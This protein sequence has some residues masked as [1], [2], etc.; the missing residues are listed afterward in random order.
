MQE[1]AKELAKAKDTLYTELKFFKKINHGFKRQETKNLK[2]VQRKGSN[3]EEEEEID[4]KNLPVKE[5]IKYLTV[6]Q[7]RE[8]SEETT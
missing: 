3:D 4:I 7:L 1:N 5:R 8:L 2:E 6:N